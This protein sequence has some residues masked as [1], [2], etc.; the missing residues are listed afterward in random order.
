MTKSEFFRDARHDLSGPLAGVRVVEATTTLAGP[1]CAATLADLGADVIKVETPQ[2]DVTRRLPPMLPGTKV[3]FAHGTINR[4]KRSLSLD[5]GRPEGCEIF[6][7]LAS[8]ADI[9]VENLKTGTMDQ[10]GV[11]YEA[12]RAVKP[13]IVYVSITGWG[14]FGPYSSR[15]GY[16][17]IAQAASG[18]MSLNGS[19]DGPPT[20][21][22]LAIGD[23]LGGLHGVIGAMAAL[24]HRD[25]TGEG[26][27]VDVALLDTLSHNDF[28]TLA[29]MGVNP[30]RNG[31]EFGFAVPSNVF[32]CHDGSVYIAV[33]LDAH[34]KVLARTISQ[35]ELADDPGFAT[36][37][38]RLANRD[39]CN[40]LVAAWTAE[41]SRAEVV[42][43]LNRVGIPVGP[44]NSYGDAA[45]DPH[46]LERDSLQPTQTEDGST[47]PL[48]GPVVK[49]SRTPTRVRTGAPALG[50]HNDE[51][52]AELGMD[53]GEIN[54][55]REC[56]IT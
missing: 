47:V 39:A 7:K 44:V 26:Q 34:W 33:L 9:V 52:L 54:R 20:K 45:R 27:H 43:I 55:L 48:P 10:W 16:D 53:L 42:E 36:L 51:I 41:H 8:Q 2:G 50:Q 38:G 46:V 17:P 23:R 22:P 30:Q 15:P 6:L 37:T 19:A 12:V 18:F 25:R 13:D 5:L 14:Q 4:N 40:A 1:S 28:L 29:A 21:D 49:F 35:A 11:G 56:G 31:N 24:H 32:A 3:S